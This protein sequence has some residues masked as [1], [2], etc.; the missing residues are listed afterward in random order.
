MM[1]GTGRRARRVQKCGDC[2]VKEGSLHEL[3]CDNEPCPFCG[4]QLIT[5]DCA[6]ELLNL[7]DP[8]KHGPETAHLPPR[9]YS[10]GLTAAL[11]KKWE[12]LLNE[13]GRT[14]FILWPIVCAR[15]G[16][17]WPEFFRVADEEWERVVEIQHRGDVLCRPCFD[18]IKRLIDSE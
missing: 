15:C 11:Q 7:L 18:E 10:K 13:K 9:I 1:T 14:P 4:G 12:R 5:C 6:Y 3:F 16:A 17:L 2:G 8:E